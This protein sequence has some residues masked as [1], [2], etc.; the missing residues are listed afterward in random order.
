MMRHHPRRFIRFLDA[1]FEI[2]PSLR[3]KH[4]AEWTLARMKEAD[5]LGFKC[6]CNAR[7]AIAAA[8]RPQ[9]C[10]SRGTWKAQRDLR[11]ADNI[12]PLP[13][14]PLSFGIYSQDFRIACLEDFRNLPF[15]PSDAEQAGNAY[16]MAAA[17]KLYRALQRWERYARDNG[18]STDPSH[19]AFCSFL[20]ETRAAIAEAERRAST[21]T[22]EDAA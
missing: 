2:R 4:I 6:R 10:Y 1:I 16:L 12:G 9:I 8:K 13:L 15:G 18:Y 21:E 22:N 19:S 5:D 14:G 11:G 3:P 7:S 20:E 17:P